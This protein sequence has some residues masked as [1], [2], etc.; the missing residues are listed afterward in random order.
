MSN[1]KKRKRQNITLGISSLPG[2]RAGDL[3]GQDVEGLLSGDTGR[4][5]GQ[6]YLSSVSGGSSKLSVH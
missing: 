4:P 1:D 5:V 3:P 6:S 2:G